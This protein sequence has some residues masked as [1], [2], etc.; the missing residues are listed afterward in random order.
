MA[1]WA[2]NW[3]KLPKMAIFDSF[4]ACRGPKMARSNLFRT[5]MTFPHIDIVIFIKKKK[6]FFFFDLTTLLVHSAY[7]VP[8]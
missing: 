6:I 1:K 8:P 2:L 4:G 3:L 7:V 5:K